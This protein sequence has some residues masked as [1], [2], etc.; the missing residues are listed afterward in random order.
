MPSDALGLELINL[1]SAEVLQTLK[2][3][4]SSWVKNPRYATATLRELAFA[5]KPE[6]ALQVLQCMGR[7]GVEVNSFHVGA[8][9]FACEKAQQWSLAMDLSQGQQMDIIGW[10]AAISSCSKG[11]HWQQSVQCLKLLHALPALHPQN[12][13]ADSADAV[14]TCTMGTTGTTG[15]ELRN[16]LLGLRL[17]VVTFS[18]VLIGIHWR[19]SI[20]LLDKMGG[21]G[22]FPNSF[23]C[24]SAIH[25]IK[26][27]SWGMA[28]ELINRMQQLQVEA[29]GVVWSALV[30]ANALYA[31]WEQA[32]C[33]LRT[34]HISRI[35]VN[36]ICQNAAITTCA[37]SSQWRSSVDLFANFP[38]G[39]SGPTGYPTVVSYTA[40]MTPFSGDF[41]LWQWPMFLLSQLRHSGLKADAYCTAAAGDPAW[42]ELSLKLFAESSRSEISYNMVTEACGKHGKWEHAMSLLKEML[43][44]VIEPS[45]STFANVM[46]ACGNSGHWRFSVHLLDEMSVLRIQ[47]TAPSSA[48]AMSA[49]SWNGRWEVALH[50]FVILESRAAEF[51]A[52]SH[53]ALISAFERGSRWQLAVEHFALVQS[54]QQ[55]TDPAL[56]RETVD[57]VGLV[58]TVMY[59]CILSALQKGSQWQSA[60]ENLGQIRRSALQIDDITC[61]VAISACEASERWEIAVGMARRAT[62]HGLQQDEVTYNALI[63]CLDRGQQW[64]LALHCT[65]K[66]TSCTLSPS[67]VTLDTL[68]HALHTE[69]KVTILQL[70]RRAMLDLTDAL[71]AVL[72]SEACEAAVLAFQWKAVLQLLGDISFKAFEAIKAVNA[73][74]TRCVQSNLSAEKLERLE[75]LEPE[76]LN[77]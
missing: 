26:W 57:T 21:C 18:S 56:N 49:C 64:P 48:A 55:H 11:G 50:L 69:W 16:E 1:N 67:S 52:V 10:N 5:S 6:V 59:N 28:A 2:P 75:R 30:G 42:W 32:T 54:L 40:L 25:S 14:T 68:A 36:D 27:R 9:L 53:S 41:Q 62:S 73:L 33:G 20:A 13:S 4:L 7:N 43:K 45:A 37:S 8:A 38:T 70:E 65:T 76:R 77:A 24:S 51:D 72:A 47:S 17:D 58:D 60:L 3:V 31:A 19:T 71:D 66:M 39:F 74:R 34:M 35:S 61:N 22:V 23:S 46:N 29:N 12:G 15:G 63:S 44:S